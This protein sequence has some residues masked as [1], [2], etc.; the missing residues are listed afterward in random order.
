MIRKNKVIEKAALMKEALQNNNA[1]GVDFA[2]MN[3]AQFV[4]GVAPSF[5]QREEYEGNLM[6][7]VGQRQEIENADEN[8]ATYVTHMRD[9][10]RCHPDYGPNSALYVQCG[11]IADN[12]RKS[13]LTRGQG[14]ADESNGSNEANGETPPPTGEAE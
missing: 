3:Y 7:A 14:D 4:S 2:G 8:S 5:D 10:I 1:T 13:G 12:Q 6:L 11:Y 9:A